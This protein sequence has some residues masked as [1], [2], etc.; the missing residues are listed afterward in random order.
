[1][2]S[3]GSNIAAMIP[4]ASP[5]WKAASSTR[6]RA[7]GKLQEPGSAAATRAARRHD[8]HR[9]YAL[10]D[11][12]RADREATPIRTPPSG[13]R[14]CTTASSRISASCARSSNSDGAKFDTETDTEVVAHLVT[15]EMKKGRTP[16]EAVRGGAA[17]AARR[18]R[19]RL[20]VRRRG[21]SADRR[22]QGLAARGRLRRRR[23]V[24]RLRRDRARAVHRHDQLSRGRRLGGG[25][26]QRA[27]RSATRSG[28]SVKRP[29]I[30]IHAPR[31]SWSTRATIATSWRRRSTSSRKSSATRW[32]ITSTW[33]PSACGCRRELPFDFAQARAA[34]RSRPAAPPT[35]P[36]WS[37]NTGSS[38]SRG[39]RSR[40]I[41][42]RSSATARRRCEP[43]DLA[44][45]VS[46]SGETADTLAS[47]RYAKE[48]KQHVLSVVNVPDLDDRARERRGDADAGRPGDRRRLDQGLHLPACGARL[49]RDRRRPRARRA[50]ARRTSASWCAR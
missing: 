12:W 11:A 15:D 27:S 42:R 21:R 44:I 46:Q 13:W 17:A 29:V 5:R 41:S 37:P 16:A 33:R 43:G 2:R 26:A 34:C 8:R 3:S 20:P 7:E 40:S 19:A 24:S 9:P 6:R 25:H 14:S 31:R 10:G 35:M 38:A 47:L 30:K 49:P 23:D 28:A 50:L 4:P 18:L 39:C 48:Q 1:M 45:F 22:A 36:G 32:R